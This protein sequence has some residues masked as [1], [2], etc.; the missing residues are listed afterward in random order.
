MA[1]EIVS[2]AGSMRG[3][4]FKVWLSRNKDNLKM[5]LMGVSAFAANAMIADPALKWGLTVAVP[6]V[7]KLVIDAID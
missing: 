7:I 6:I 5:L 1:K 3:Y 4:S 2:A